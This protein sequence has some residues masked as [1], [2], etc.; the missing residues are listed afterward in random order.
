M[1][2]LMLYTVY[3]LML[4]IYIYMYNVNILSIVWRR[5]KADTVTWQ[6]N[7]IFMRYF[8]EK[9]VCCGS[10]SCLTGSDLSINTSGSERSCEYS[11][12]LAKA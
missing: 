6:T 9:P 7:K 12:V 8:V 4:Y 1:Y 3:I 2:S 10:G 5:A 11:F